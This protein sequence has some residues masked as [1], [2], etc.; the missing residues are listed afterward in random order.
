MKNSQIKK[1]FWTLIVLFVIIISFIFCPYDGIWKN[2]LFPFVGILALVFLILGLVLYF[3]VRRMKF[4]D[5]WLKRWFIV[6]GISPAGAVLSSILHNLISGIG[7]YLGYAEFEEPVF[8]LLAVIGF[9]LLFLVG[10]FG[11]LWLGRR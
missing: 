2:K 6:V 11:V 3:K 5:K 7:I 1:I 4:K 9:P 10:V 8:F